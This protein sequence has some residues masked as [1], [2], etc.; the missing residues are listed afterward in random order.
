MNIAFCWKLLFTGEV[1]FFPLHTPINYWLIKANTLAYIMC[2]VC[3]P[4]P[5]HLK[6]STSWASQYIPGYHIFGQKGEN[7][8]ADILN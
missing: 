3:I 2:L 5:S 8:I 1:L 6:Q 7:G 4:S